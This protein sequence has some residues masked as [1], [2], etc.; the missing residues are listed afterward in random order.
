[1]I[2]VRSSI[3]EA[4][5]PRCRSWP[6]A[7]TV[8][9]SPTPKLFAVATPRVLART[10]VTSSCGGGGRI[11]NLVLAPSHSLKGPVPSL[12]FCW[13]AMQNNQTNEQKRCFS[14][15]QAAGQGTWGHVPGNASDLI[16]LD[17]SFQVNR[18]D[19]EVKLGSVI[20]A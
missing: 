17:V 9:T 12:K 2:P 16:P 1:M 7:I 6:R 5:D 10:S 13:R 8:G 19:L 14:M 4:R 18:S 11:K 20:Q 3:L 15:G